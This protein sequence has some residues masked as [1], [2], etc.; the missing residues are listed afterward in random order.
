MANFGPIVDCYNPKI[1]RIVISRSFYKKKIDLF[2]IIPKQISN[3]SSLLIGPIEFLIG[4][5]L[6]CLVDYLTAYGRF[7]F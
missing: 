7:D 3:Q 4:S 1:I 5:K 6:V 2:Y